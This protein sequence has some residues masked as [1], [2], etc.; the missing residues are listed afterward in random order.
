MVLA[1]L[2]LLELMVATFGIGVVGSLAGL[3]LGNLRLPFLLGVLPPSIAGGTNVSVSGLGAGAG[4]LTHLREGRFDRT[5][6]WIMTPPSV[7]GAL[8]GGYLSGLVPGRYL[9]LAVALIVLEQGAELLRATAAR[10]PDRGPPSPPSRDTRWGVVLGSLG[11][12]IG[13]LGGLVGLIL[14]TLR[15]PAMLR[16]GIAVKD[17]VATNLAVGFFLG[18]AAMVGHILGGTIDLFL[19]LL[20]APPAIVGAVVGVRLAS[21]VS[22]QHLKQIVGVTLLGVGAA[23]LAFLALGIRPA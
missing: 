7:A 2:T 17:A 3:V 4:V 13:V 5:A 19:V 11:F 9:I 15:L 6:F 22:E 21:G 10:F 1:P 14:G 12:G 20:L 16:E 23:L 8:I 18:L